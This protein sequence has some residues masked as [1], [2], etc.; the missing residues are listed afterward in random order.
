MPKIPAV[1]LLFP[2]CPFLSS[3][4]YRVFESK[5]VNPENSLISETCLISNKPCKPFY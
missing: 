3:L 4:T 2:F 5:K 1:L